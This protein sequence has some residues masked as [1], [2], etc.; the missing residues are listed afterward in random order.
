MAVGG[1]QEGVVVTGGGDSTVALWRDS[2]AAN[3]E[4]AAEEEAAAVLKQQD[5]ENALQVESETLS[6]NLWRR[7][8]CQS[9]RLLRGSMNAP[10]CDCATL[11]VLVRG[12]HKRRAR[13]DFRAE[14]PSGVTQR[15]AVSSP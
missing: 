3:A 8:G 11:C 2:T 4:A 5:L 15:A 12:C 10:P 1:K 14:P 6:P 9:L 13:G 7:Q